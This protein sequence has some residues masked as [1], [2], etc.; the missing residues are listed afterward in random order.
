MRK[1]KVW[2][3]PVGM[4]VSTSAAAISGDAAAKS[5]HGPWTVAF[6]LLALLLTT[7][8]WMPVAKISSP[9]TAAITEGF[10]TYYQSAA[11]RGDKI[12]ANPPQYTY[13]NYP[14]V[15]FHLVAWLGSRD[16]NVT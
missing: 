13:A 7:L 14:P 6:C 4:P 3:E 2:Q 9:S 11:A 10:N 5:G 8:I 15:S 16:L 1:K 12:Y